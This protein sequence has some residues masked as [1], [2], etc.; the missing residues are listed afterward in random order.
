MQTAYGIK[1]LLWFV[2]PD[3]KQYY[4]N[5]QFCDITKCSGIPG[6]GFGGGGGGGGG[7]RPPPPGGGGIVITAMN[8]GVP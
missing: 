2:I 6:G 5:F 3:Y 1:N 7:P 8:F 4:C